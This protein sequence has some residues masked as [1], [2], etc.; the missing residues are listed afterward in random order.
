MPYSIRQRLLVFL[1]VLT[2]TGWSIIALSSYFEARNEIETLFDAHLLQSAKVLL[3][4][5]DQELYEE[6]TDGGKIL[7]G[8]R[9]KM[10]LKDI[11]EHLVKHTYEKLLAF[12]ISIKRD[13]FS[14]S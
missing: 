8:N 9:E 11:K 6:K 4:L 2:I 10:E 13:N 12:Q 5:V 1:L 14:F 7:S 3:S